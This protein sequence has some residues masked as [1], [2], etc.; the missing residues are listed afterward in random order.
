MEIKTS[1]QTLEINEVG[2]YVYLLKDNKMYS[3]Q[4]DEVKVSQYYGADGKI[5]MGILYM[6]AGDWYMHSEVYTDTEKVMEYL[7]NTCEMIA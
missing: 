5:R 3:G 6:V 1:S 4:I 7:K 2:K